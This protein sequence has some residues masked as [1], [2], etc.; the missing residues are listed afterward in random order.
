MAIQYFSS[1]NNGSF[2]RPLSYTFPAG[3][4]TLVAAAG[5]IEYLVGAGGGGSGGVYAGGGGAGGYRT[6]SG[7][8]V[9]QGTVY[10]VTIGAGGT[11][12]T[13][14]T[15]GN[16]GS[17]SSRWIYG[18]VSTTPGSGEFTTDDSDISA[19]SNFQISDNNSTG[20]NFDAWFTLI[21][22]YINKY[23]FYKYIGE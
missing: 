12:T 19:T 21:Q 8:S 3:L 15:Q 7:V 4:N 1:D 14:S 5:S 13:G 23:L 22:T 20:T 18:G 9:N 16:D 10:T 2:V 11:G 17:N 6:A